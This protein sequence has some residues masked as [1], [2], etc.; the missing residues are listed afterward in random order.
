MG[1]FPISELPDM[2]EVSMFDIH[3][4]HSD[5]KNL[6]FARNIYFCKEISVGKKRHVSCRR[7]PLLTFDL[8][9]TIE[10]EFNML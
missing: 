10:L 9:N 4:L 3:P 1:K 5:S 7:D 2:V 6:L 8:T